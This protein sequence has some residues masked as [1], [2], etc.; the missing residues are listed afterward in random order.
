MKKVLIF[1]ILSIV[2]YAVICQTKTPT[3]QWLKNYS[4]ESEDQVRDIIQLSNNNYIVVGNSYS[5]GIRE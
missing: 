1:S 3:I 4:G 2:T 5:A